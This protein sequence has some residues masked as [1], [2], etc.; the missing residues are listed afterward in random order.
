MSGRGLYNQFRLELQH[1]SLLDCPFNIYT[2]IIGCYIPI[3][4][5]ETYSVA[6]VTCKTHEILMTGLIRYHKYFTDSCSTWYKTIKLV[7]VLNRKLFTMCNKIEST[8]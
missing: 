8:A 5:I 4:N 1:L 7:S 6:L 2:L 3:L